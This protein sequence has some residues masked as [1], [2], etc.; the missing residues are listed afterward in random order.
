MKM[1]RSDGLLSG[2]ISAMFF[3]ARAYATGSGIGVGVVGQ[4]RPLF[5]G[6][7]VRSKDCSRESRGVGATGLVSYPDW[8]RGRSWPLSPTWQRNGAR[9]PLVGGRKEGG[10]LLARGLSWAAAFCAWLGRGKGRGWGV[11]LRAK[12][13]GEGSSFFFISCFSFLLK[14]KY[15]KIFS[16]TKTKLFQNIFK[17]RIWIPFQS[18]SK[19]RTTINPSARACMLKQVA[20]PI[21]NFNLKKNIIFPIFHGHK[22]T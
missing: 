21:V 5:K 22:N 12:T 11:G 3:S 10:G 1:R 7:N 13:K 18:L 9:D 19:P 17:T 20:N 15:F 2:W 14:Q 4:R 8:D 6:A 16:K